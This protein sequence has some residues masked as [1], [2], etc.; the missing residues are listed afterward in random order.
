MSSRLF[1][2]FFLFICL[3]VYAEDGPKQAG[4]KGGPDVGDAAPNFQATVLGSDVKVELAEVLKAEK[5][6]VVLIF[7]SST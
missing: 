1:S 2:G 7:G 5:K 3:G 4:K 6:P